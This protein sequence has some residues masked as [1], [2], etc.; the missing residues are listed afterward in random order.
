MLP[1]RKKPE[2]ASLPPRPPSRR[3]RAIA[4][5]CAI[6]DGRYQDACSILNDL[7]MDDLIAT[8]DGLYI[9]YPF[10]PLTEYVSRATGIFKER[11][12]V[13]IYAVTGVEDTKIAPYLLLLPPGQQQLIRARVAAGQTAKSFVVPLSLRSRINRQDTKTPGFKKCDGSGILIPRILCCVLDGR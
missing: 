10:K 5:R 4:R 1:E 11:L 7:S 2:D 13:A 6:F 8:L 9:T 3:S 12:L